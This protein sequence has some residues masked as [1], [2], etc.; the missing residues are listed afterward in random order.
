MKDWGKQR[1]KNINTGHKGLRIKTIMNMVREKEGDKVN[2]G[3]NLF[4]KV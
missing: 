1:V 2:E 3:I 4:G